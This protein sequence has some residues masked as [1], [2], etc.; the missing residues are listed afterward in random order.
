MYVYTYVCTVCMY[1]WMDDLFMY[2]CT[3]VNM[4]VCMYMAFLKLPVTL[5]VFSVFLQ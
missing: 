4:S 5:H 3:F 1:S 2:L